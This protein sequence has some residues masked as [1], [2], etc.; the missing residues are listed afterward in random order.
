LVAIVARNFSWLQR[1]RDSLLAGYSPQAGSKRSSSVA[2]L[3][4]MKVASLTETLDLA[5]AAA[6]LDHIDVA[7]RPRLLSDNGSS[8]V[9][10]DLASWLDSQ[11][12]KHIRGT[13]HHPMTQGKIERR[14]QTMK[15]RILLENYY[16]PGDLEATI[17]GFVHHYKH[18]RYQESLKN[19]T[20]ANVY[21]G[22]GPSILHR[23]E[24]IKRRTIEHRRLLHQR[25]TA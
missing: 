5:M 15:N 22:C 1:R 10:T 11:G 9:A 24:A 7:Q 4:V 6:G 3:A 18:H 19:I 14:H 17:A 12:I 8:Y 25:A 23:R 13:P 16:L 2:S 20:P 21:A